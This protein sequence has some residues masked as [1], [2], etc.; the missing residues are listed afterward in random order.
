M[1]TSAQRAAGPNRPAG[2]EIREGLLWEVTPEV[3]SGKNARIGEE[4]GS[5]R[6]KSHLPQC[7]SWGCSGNIIWFVM[8][9]PEYASEGE[10]GLGQWVGRKRIDKEGPS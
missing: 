7:R 5:E 10:T 2:G 8:A 3:T 9:G 6:G 1:R 4:E